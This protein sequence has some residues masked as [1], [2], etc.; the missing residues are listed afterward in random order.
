MLRGPETI[1]TRD[2]LGCNITSSFAVAEYRVDTMVVS[3]SLSSWSRYSDASYLEKQ[4]A[5]C[6]TGSL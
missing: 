3:A 1:A 4:S 2:M 5:I 6:E